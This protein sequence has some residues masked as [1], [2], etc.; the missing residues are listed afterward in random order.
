MSFRY[1][2]LYRT[3]EP[4]GRQNGIIAQP[5]IYPDLGFSIVGV[6]RHNCPAAAASPS[7]TKR[8]FSHQTTCTIEEIKAWAR[9]HGASMGGKLGAYAKALAGKAGKS[10]EAAKKVAVVSLASAIGMNGSEFP[11]SAATPAALPLAVVPSGAGHTLGCSFKLT[12][13]KVCVGS[14]IGRPWSAATAMECERTCSQANVNSNSG[15][16]GCEWHEASNLCRLKKRCLLKYSADA[17]TWAGTCSV[18]VSQANPSIMPLSVRPFPS[19]QPTQPLALQPT[20]MPSPCATN[21]VR[22]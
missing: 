20:T 21:K 15:A 13:K 3:F 22:I 14:W 6:S 16:E 7:K 18:H 10:D 19:A 5:W 1:E 2:G 11:K 12:R 8:S 4:G 9:K 17:L